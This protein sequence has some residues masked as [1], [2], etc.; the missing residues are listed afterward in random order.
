MSAATMKDVAEHAGVSTATVSRALMNPEKVSAATR[1]KVEQ[2]VLAVGYSPHALA[3]SSK[4][5]ESRTILV[6]V[7]DI[8]DPFFAEVIQG[9]ERT[10]AEH[11]YLVLL[12]DCAQQQQQEKTFVNL[13]ITKQIDGM[14]LLGSNVPFDA[15][16]EE[17]KNLPP[18]VMA[19]E[20]APE[21]FIERGDFTYEAGAQAMLALMSLPQPPT[22]IFCHSDA[23]AIRALSQAKRMGLR[24][25]DDVSLVGFDDIKLAQYCD[26]PL[27]TVSQP[28]YQIGREAMLLLLEQ[29][30]SR[31]VVSGSRLLDSEFIVRGSTSAPKR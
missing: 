28:R 2:A 9:V 14:L 31:S 1:Q 12:G 30:H 18:M 8:C 7:P 10:A 25:P 6:I 23:M 15:S 21:S 5:N 27:T 29:L 4:R 11:G 3:R 22:A 16:K 24:V 19:N 20:F 17:Q 13:I 26:P